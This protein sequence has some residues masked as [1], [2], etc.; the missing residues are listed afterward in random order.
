MNIRFLQVIFFF[1]MG[2]IGCWAL[3]Q[4]L[5]WSLFVSSALVGLIGSFIPT[6]KTLNNHDTSAIIYAGS[7][8]GMS[9]V[10]IIPH[11][12]YLIVLGMIGGFTYYKFTPYFIGLG[13][14]LGTIAFISSLSLLLILGALAW[15][16]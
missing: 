16:F 2:L 14:K 1:S 8:A 15:E 5:N 3:N 12:A 7:F 4:Y 6:S 9:S 13:G 10:S 11:P